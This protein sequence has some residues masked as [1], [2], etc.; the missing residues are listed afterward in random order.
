MSLD[1][2][3]ETAK[4]DVTQLSTAPGN[5]VKLEL[6]AL[7]KQASIGDVQGDKPGGFDFVGK[8]KYDAWAGK[9]GLTTDEAKQAYLDLVERLKAEDQG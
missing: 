7:Y 2:L 3:F 5:D 8:A 6:Y 1:D 9:Q 4:A